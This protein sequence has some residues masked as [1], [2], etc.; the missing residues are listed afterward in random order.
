MEPLRKSVEQI[1][2]AA[3]ELLLEAAKTGTVV[4]EKEGVGNF[5]TDCDLATQQFLQ[6]EL[7]GLLPGSA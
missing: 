6:R 4:H 2:L 7:K 1:V 3:G 5:V